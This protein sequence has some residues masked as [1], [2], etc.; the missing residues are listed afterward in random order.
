MG[1][2][3]S[4]DATNTSVGESSSV[5]LP[6]KASPHSI[7]SSTEQNLK[8]KV[9]SQA[10][11]G[12]GSGISSSTLKNDTVS[13]KAFALQDKVIFILNATLTHMMNYILYTKDALEVSK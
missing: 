12:G 6:S 1:N 9:I 7:S 11:V 3:R 2:I 8:A 10:E 4:I 5:T 13:R